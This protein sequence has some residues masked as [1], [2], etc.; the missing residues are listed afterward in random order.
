MNLRVQLSGTLLCAFWLTA[1]TAEVGEDLESSQE[2]IINGDVPTDGSL[3]A[4]GVVKLMMWPGAGGCSGTLI[5]NQHVLTARHCVRE[6]FGF[7]DD[8]YA[9]I[10]ATLEGPGGVDQVIDAVEVW[11]GDGPDLWDDYAI[12]QLS[13][14]VTIGGQSN[15]HYNAIYTPDDINLANQDLFCV[16]YGNNQLATTTQYQQGFGT[17]RTATI[18]TLGT[19]RLSP[20]NYFTV[21]WTGGKI[22]TSGDSGSTCFLSSSSNT[23]TG[24]M[25]S[26]YC[27][28]TDLNGDGDVSSSECSAID[29]CRYMS[30]G[31]FRTWANGIVRTSVVVPK[32]INLPPLPSGTTLSSRVTTVTGTNST[33]SALTNRTISA[34]ALRAG[35]VQV[36]AATEPARTL[37]PKKRYT[38][39]LTGNATA[40]NY[41]LGDG[42]VSS[43]VSIIPG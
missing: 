2:S 40:Q 19:D 5:S 8:A 41:C 13:S 36:E 20:T 3:Q 28:G 43:L 16:G 24:V 42:L 39:P 25:S 30:P 1:C 4:K 34:A 23:I 26:C 15:A 17:L 22:T 7:W 32:F 9:V 37:C 27:D 6:W 38:A 10:W 18:R 14:P 12:F 31:N 11:E 21:D 33:A 29:D 35:W